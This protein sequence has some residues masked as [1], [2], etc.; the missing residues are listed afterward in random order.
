L[1]RGAALSALLHG[2]ILLLVFL[3]W[4]VVPSAAP[5]PSGPPPIPID[6][7]E[8]GPETRSPDG[9]KSPVPQQRATET[10]DHPMPEAIPVPKQAALVKAPG[11][12]A[13][14]KDQDQSQPD[15]HRRPAP[16]PQEGEGISNTTTGADGAVTGKAA[17]GVKDYVRAQIER[18]WYPQGSALLRNDWVVQLH[19]QLNQDGSIG[20]A[21]II[22]GGKMGDAAYRDFAYSVRNAALLSAPFTLPPGLEDRTRDLTLEF[23]PRRV[24]E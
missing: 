3:L 14:H 12:K 6:L 4:S 2:V 8:E 17:Y 24:Q 1:L 19:L 7:V 20:K 21:E 22:D 5:R 9:E 11:K 18:R 15:P 23:N 16:E 10:A 13:T